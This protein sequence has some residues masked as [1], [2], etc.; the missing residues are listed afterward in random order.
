MNNNTFNIDEVMKEITK[1]VFTS[2]VDF[3]LEMALAIKRIYTEATVICEYPICTDGKE[4]EVEYS[5]KEDKDAAYNAEKVKSRRIHIDIVVL[6][7]GKYYPIELKYRTAKIEKCKLAEDEQAS[8]SLVSQGAHDAGCYGFVRDICRIAEM[9]KVFG[10]NF[11]EGYA[12]FLTNDGKYWETIPNDRDYREI[13][14]VDRN[15]RPTIVKNDEK[16]CVVAK[17][18]GMFRKLVVPEYDVS[19]IK[20]SDHMTF[21]YIVAT[22]A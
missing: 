7:G 17:V 11:G 19:D 16:G 13:W 8:F 18:N 22:I 2:E 1:R 10:E 15:S 9:K 6:L 21:K 4:L 20:T 12:V 5:P 14:L 3:Q